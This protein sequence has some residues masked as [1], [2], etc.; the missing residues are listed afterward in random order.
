MGSRRF[1]LTFITV[2]MGIVLVTVCGLIIVASWS[3]HSRTSTTSDHEPGAVQ[4]SSSPASTGSSIDEASHAP[5]ISALAARGSVPTRSVTVLDTLPWP[6]DAFTEGLDRLP[7]GQTL[8][9]T[10]RYGKSEVYFLNDD[11]DRAHVHHLPRK[12]FGEGIAATQT[13]VWQLTWTSG[14]AIRRDRRSLAATGS[15]HYEGEGWGLCYDGHRLL[16]SDGSNRLTRREPDTF[17]ERSSLSV[18]LGGRPVGNINELDCDHNRIVANVWHS[19]ELIV[20]DP[21]NGRV[22]SVIDA[23]GLAPERDATGEN[24]LNGVASDPEDPDVLYVT[25]KLWPHMYRVRVDGLG[26]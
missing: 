5:S 10:G 6:R 8:V 16:M 15:A 23:S 26:G 18:T 14:H 4:D 11:G 19:D 13:S 7:H 3:H 20:V 9:S 2:L 22:T 25:G 17:E 24:V 21:A 1:R 12:Y